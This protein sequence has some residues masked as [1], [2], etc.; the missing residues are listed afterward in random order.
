MGL[1][2]NSRLETG[3]KLALQQLRTLR[4]IWSR[5]KT[6]LIDVAKTL[7][8]DKAQVT[9]LVD[10][11]CKA[12]MVTREPNPDDGRS[13]ILKIT[14]AGRQFFEKVE[15]IEEQFSKELTKGIS[16]QELQTFFAVS[17][18]LSDNLRDIELP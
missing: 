13:K 14:R 12:N 16:T 3:S 18:R 2:I 7:K 15:Q 5:D 9:R 6:T 1:Q 10:E 11:L 17:D 4:L 8:R